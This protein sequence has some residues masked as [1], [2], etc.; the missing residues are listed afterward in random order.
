[1]ARQRLA[2]VGCGYVSR[3]HLTAWQRVPD[4][5]VVALCDVQADRCAARAREF[6]VT[7]HYTDVEAMLSR[8]A[9]DAVDVAT[10]PDAH[11]PV[12]DAAARAGVHVLCQK[13][14]ALTLAEGRRLVDTCERAGVRLMVNENWRWRPWFRRLKALLGDGMIGTPVYCQLWY[15]QAATVRDPTAPEAYALERRPYFRSMPGLV[16]L[17]QSVHYFDVL[18]Y[19][20]GPA[21]RVSAIC[22]RVSHEIVGED[23]AAVLIETG[24]PIIDLQVSWCSHGYTYPSHDARVIVEGTTGTAILDHDAVLRVRA[25]EGG[26]RVVFAPTDDGYLESFV[27]AHRHFATGLIQDEPFETDGHAYL[28]TMAVAEAVLQSS[29]DRRVIEIDHV[30]IGSVFAHE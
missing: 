19:L 23:L 30:R 3:T 25:G 6:G 11:A 29:R 18:A 21:V 20:F 15:R 2:L 27:A 1:M 22:R 17:E 4:V 26:D 16:V 24:G 13:P 7:G 12:V 5:E 28:H 14:L 10:P 9:L 8:E